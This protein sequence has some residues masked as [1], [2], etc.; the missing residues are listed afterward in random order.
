M[1]CLACVINNRKSNSFC[2]SKRGW[3][4]INRDVDNSLIEFGV[5]LDTNQTIV[6]RQQRELNKKMETNLIITC[7]I[8][9]FKKFNKWSDL[10]WN[11]IFIIICIEIIIYRFTL[12]RTDLSNK[13]NFCDGILEIRFGDHICVTRHR[14]YEL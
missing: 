1:Y 11:R 4:N 12:N 13:G 6:M 5:R 3:V 7:H 10:W 14:F 9:T 8:F 2:A